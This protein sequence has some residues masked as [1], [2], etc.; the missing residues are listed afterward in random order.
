V[1]FFSAFQTNAYWDRQYQ[2]NSGQSAPQDQPVP[3]VNIKLRDPYNNYKRQD[4][5]IDNLIDK[6][7][8]EERNLQQTESAVIDLTKRAQELKLEQIRLDRIGQE[9]QSS[10]MGKEIE[11]LMVFIAM[12]AEKVRKS[13]NNMAFL[14]LMMSDPFIGAG[15]VRILH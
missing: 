6:Y 5:C 7:R 2:I 4:E 14:V 10:L 15:G 11:R 13:R 12:E 9:I 8:N 3:N 1:A